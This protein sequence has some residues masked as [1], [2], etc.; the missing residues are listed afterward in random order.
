MPRKPESSNWST[1]AK[2]ADDE[3]GCCDRD[4]S[5]AHTHHGS[6]VVTH[7][8]VAGGSSVTGNAMCDGSGCDLPA[9]AG[10]NVHCLQTMQVRGSHHTSS[11]VQCTCNNGGLEILCTAIA[12]LCFVSFVMVLHEHLASF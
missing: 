5:G 7:I 3:R 1:V 10:L 12:T 11:Y 9:G 2:G 4:S 8:G 6:V